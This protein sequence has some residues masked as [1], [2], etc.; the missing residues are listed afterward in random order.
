LDVSLL[1]NNLIAPILGIDD[2][3]RDKRIDFVG[4]IRGLGELEKRVDSGEMAL[5]LALHATSMEDLMA[6]ADANEVMPPK[7]TWFEPKLADGW[8][9]ICLCVSY[10]CCAESHE[11]ADF[12]DVFE[13]FIRTAGANN[14]KALVIGNWGDDPGISSKEVVSLLVAHKADL[15]ELKALF[16]GNISQEESEISWIEQS[17]VSPLFG[18]YPKLEVLKIRGGNNLSLGQL[19]HPALNTLIIETGGLSHRVVDQLMASKLPALRHLELW[20]GDDEYGNSCKP[21]HFAP[22]FGCC[23]FNGLEY[24]G[25]RNVQGVDSY[26]KVFAKAPIVEQIKVLDLSLGDL[27]DVG[28]E[29]LLQS[30]RL[31]GLKLLDLHHHYLSNAMVKRLRALPIKVNL[32]EQLEPE[33]WDDDELYRSIFVS[34]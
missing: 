7:S 10:G 31:S 28:G 22:L 15:P 25:L 2:P 18:A 17:D 9:R 33:E 6:V 5:A 14:V 8:R 12:K 4:G 24:L 19:E 27:S 1:Q 29:A 23:K 20:L 21:E 3:R 13:A 34:E 32:A 30:N 26:A 11:K 16:V